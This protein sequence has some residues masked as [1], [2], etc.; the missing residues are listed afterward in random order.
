MDYL[1][2]LLLIP[3]AFVGTLTLLVIDVPPETIQDA[4]SV[5][6]VLVGLYLAVISVV[7]WIWR[8]PGGFLGHSWTTWLV[9]MLIAYSAG[10]SLGFVF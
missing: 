2:A 1:K 10:L 9:L 3:V 5:Y 6:A 7:I 4:V 8:R